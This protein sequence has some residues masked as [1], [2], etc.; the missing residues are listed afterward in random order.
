MFVA[1]KILNQEQYIILQSYKQTL[2]HGFPKRKTFEA[3]F[4]IRGA[5]NG[6][7]AKKKELSTKIM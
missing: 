6:Q 4:A 7:K 1:V 3:T 5:I 2:D